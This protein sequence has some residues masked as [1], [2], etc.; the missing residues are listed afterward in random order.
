VELVR[1][2][3]DWYPRLKVLFVSG[4]SEELL[5]SHGFA[6]GSVRYLAKPFTAPKLAA[7]MRALLDD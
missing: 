3:H 2:L 6:P 7:E 4:Y 1:N 5:E